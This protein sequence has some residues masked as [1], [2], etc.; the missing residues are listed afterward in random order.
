[1]KHG[2]Y[3]EILKSNDIVYKENNN[4]TIKFYYRG[5][6][7]LL[8]TKTNQVSECH[9]HSKGCQI[10]HTGYSLEGYLLNNK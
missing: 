6:T 3:I 1:M 5:N 10:K 4:D 8:Y 2:Y 9:K 7:C